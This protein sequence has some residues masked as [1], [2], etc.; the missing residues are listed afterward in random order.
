[1]KNLILI[2]GDDFLAIK[3]KA[4]AIADLLKENSKNDFS[5][6]TIAGDPD[7]NTK[8]TDILK[9]F[10]LAIDTPPFL[11][12]SK[13]IWLKH[14]AFFDLLTTKG[15][16]EFQNL[17][18]TIT[19]LLASNITSENII[20]LIDGPGLT[21]TSMLY[22]LFQ[23]NGEVYDLQQIKSADKNYQIKLRNKI[24]ELSNKE[25]KSL[26]I[27]A[28]E[29]FVES[30]GGDTGRLLNELAK[31]ISYIGNKKQIE[32]EDCQAICSKTLEMANWSF[33]EA[34]AE[35]NIKAAFN[36]LNILI[37]KI[38]SE[39]TSSSNPELLMLYN[40]IRKFQDILKVKAGV[41]KLT[42]P[43]NCNY[44]NFI[45]SLEQHPTSKDNIL[46]SM[47]P[48]RAFKLYEQSKK[49]TNQKILKI[50]ET[51]I[52]ANK[53]LVS[54]INTQ[55]IILENLISEISA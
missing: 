36:A 34:L 47:H 7:N 35:K 55:R 33:A 50:F 16:S 40:I 43:K 10:I 44:N 27:D 41:E 30:I 39:K 3:S 21:S 37:D 11:A 45:S 54:G 53:E 2:T 12:K 18:N 9:E 20:V 32:L 4:N 46:F 19:D 48:Y 38:T 49:F 25:N 26:S 42:I 22:K 51:L 1:M 17:I 8:P 6:E 14:F 15:K 5:I 28:M 24:Q 13:I 29:F 23:A 31:V 52:E